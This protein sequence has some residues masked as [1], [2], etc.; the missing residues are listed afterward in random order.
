MPCGNGLGE[1]HSPVDH[2]VIADAG[3]AAE[4][5]GASID[6]DV[7]T[8]G[9]VALHTAQQSAAFIPRETL[10]PEGHAL[11]DATV[12]ADLRRLADDDAGSV[13]D[14]ERL[15]NCRAGVNVDAGSGVRLF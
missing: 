12:I 4:Y 9:R 3:I 2:A 6:G 11:I 5:G 8:E 1:K 10:G 13:I 14:E 7:M 15:A